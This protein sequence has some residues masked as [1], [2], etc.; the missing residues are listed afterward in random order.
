MPTFYFVRHAK[1]GS[2]SHWDADDRLRPLSKK[3][4]KQAEALVTVL[5]AYAITDVLTSPYLRCVQTVE[6]L[7]AVRGLELKKTP[8]LAEGYGLN[9][10]LELVREA[11]LQQAVLCTHGDVVWELVDYLVERRIVKPSEGGFEKGCT[12]VVDVEDEA[13]VRAQFIPAP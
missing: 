5:A 11:K 4:L 8:A 12:W 7:A 2:R 6:P 9:G 13:P 1:A 3:G 10:A